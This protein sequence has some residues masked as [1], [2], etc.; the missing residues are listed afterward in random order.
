VS[1]EQY[2]SSRRDAKSWRNKSPNPFGQAMTEV[3]DRIVRVGKPDCDPQL[4]LA[5]AVAA[6]PAPARKPGLG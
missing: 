5:A 3:E 4:H 1:G 2:H 6:W